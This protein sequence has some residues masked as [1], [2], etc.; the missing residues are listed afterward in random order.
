M[1]LRDASLDL[2]A[3]LRFL[4]FLL[5]ARVAPCE[6]DHV[7]RFWKVSARWVKVERMCIRRVL[8]YEDPVRHYHANFFQSF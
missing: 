6:G 7:W 1:D 8:D 4:G 3:L 5:L 2:R